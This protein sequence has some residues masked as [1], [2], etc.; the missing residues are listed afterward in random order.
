MALRPP[1]GRWHNFKFI[2]V[3]TFPLCLD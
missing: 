2:I 3:K 1:V